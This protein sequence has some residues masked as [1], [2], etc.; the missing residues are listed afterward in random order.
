M[1]C[2]SVLSFEI[3]QGS[4]GFVLGKRSSHGITCQVRH[5]PPAS[6]RH[7]PSPHVRPGA[8]A[9]ARTAGVLSHSE[10]GVK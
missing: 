8:L 5:H 6:A 10:Y 4:V 2:R 1:Q 7:W 3:G 9:T